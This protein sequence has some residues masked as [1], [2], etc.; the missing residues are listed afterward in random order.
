MFS[1]LQLISKS[2][3]CKGFY[4]II[5]DPYHYGYIDNIYIQSP[6]IDTPIIDYCCLIKRPVIRYFHST[7]RFPKIKRRVRKR[8]QS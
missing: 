8:M 6:K 2:S 7:Y 3:E 1:F 5:G 4:T